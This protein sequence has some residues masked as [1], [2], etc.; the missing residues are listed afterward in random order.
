VRR[1]AVGYDGS[2]RGT[3]AL[4]L[5]RALAELAG[6]AVAVAVALVFPDGRQHARR[7][8]GGLSAA[9]APARRRPSVVARARHRL[10]PDGRR[11][12]RS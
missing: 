7:A 11:A 2:E 4:T 3:D 8:H 9:A 12:S 10:T 5:G 6:G 1:I